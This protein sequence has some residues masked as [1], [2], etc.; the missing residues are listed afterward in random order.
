MFHMDTPYHLWLVF[1][2]QLVQ[3]DDFKTT[4]TKTFDE[5]KSTMVM[6]KLSVL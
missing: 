5:Q 6:A 2:T 4:S 3:N 1:K